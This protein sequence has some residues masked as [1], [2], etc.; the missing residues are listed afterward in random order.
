MTC[1]KRKRAASGGAGAH[2][3]CIL[4]KNHKGNCRCTCGQRYKPTLRPY[5]RKY[6]IRVYGYEKEIKP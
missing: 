6:R 5:N 2:H 4:D 1:G 3:I